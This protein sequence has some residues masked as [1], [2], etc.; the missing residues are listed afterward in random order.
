MSHEDE[1]RELFHDTF[2]H[3]SDTKSDIIDA[4]CDPERDMEDEEVIHAN[5]RMLARYRQLELLSAALS[6]A[7]DFGSPH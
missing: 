3:I 7:L 1:G 5:S 2:V 4:L 6:A